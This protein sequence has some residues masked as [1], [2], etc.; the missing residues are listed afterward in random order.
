MDHQ[1][2]FVCFLA[3]FKGENVLHTDAIETTRY[4][5]R[6]TSGSRAEIH[7]LASVFAF[8]SRL[9]FEPFSLFR[10]S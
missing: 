9:K 8:I 10:L 1:N 5:V 3:S 7:Y 4:V 2:D 6:C